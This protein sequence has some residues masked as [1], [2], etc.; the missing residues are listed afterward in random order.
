MTDQQAI[1]LRSG[2]YQWTKDI[3]CFDV[4][5]DWR[6]ERV[7]FTKIKNKIKKNTVQIKVND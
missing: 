6:V 4:I 1:E 3:A 5:E 2:G 7:M